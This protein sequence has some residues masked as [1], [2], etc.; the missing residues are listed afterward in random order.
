MGTYSGNLAPGTTSVGSSSNAYLYFEKGGTFTWDTVSARS[1]ATAEMIARDESYVICWLTT[2]D[3]SDV[4]VTVMV[5]SNTRQ[6]Y[7]VGLSVNVPENGWVKLSTQR[8]NCDVYNTS[9]NRRIY[10]VNTGTGIAGASVNFYDAAF[11]L[12]YNPSFVVNGNNDGYIYHVD[13]EPE[14]WTGYPKDK[15]GY[16]TNWG[17]WKLD[18]QNDGYPWV[19]GYLPIGRTGVLVKSTENYKDADVLKKGV[20]GWEE[21]NKEDILAL[22]GY[23]SEYM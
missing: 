1:F 15:F 6:Y 10:N 13:T 9:L 8:A 20:N 23:I 14:D 11:T 17:V 7:N 5:D 18:G 21:G 2:S 3:G 12:T 22:I 19:T 4:S 16:P